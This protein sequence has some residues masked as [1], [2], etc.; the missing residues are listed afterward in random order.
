M[1]VVSTGFDVSA[2]Q[3][4]PYGGRQC[5]VEGSGRGRSATLHQFYTRM[6]HDVPGHAPHRQQSMHASHR[7]SFARSA[8]K[9]TPHRTPAQKHL[10]LRPPL[11]RSGVPLSAGSSSAGCRAA[12]CRSASCCTAS[13][14]W[15]APARRFA[16]V[17]A[18]SASAA[19]HDGGSGAKREAPWPPPPPP[20]RLLPGC[21]VPCASCSSSA[22]QKKEHCV[23]LQRE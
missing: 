11:P 5:T 23:L 4:F 7:R 15:A 10:M 16:D 17:A 21:E 3:R 13:G 20:P 19:Y 9:L 2:T 1:A 8:G 14:R 22:R 18:A 6:V 12:P